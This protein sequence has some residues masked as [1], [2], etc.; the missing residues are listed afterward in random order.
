MPLTFA[1]VIGDPIAH[2]KSPLIH[3]FWLQRLGL[4]GS[5]RATRVAAPQLPDYFKER[6]ANPNWRGCNVTVPH[7]EAV[8]PLIDDLTAMA[9]TVGAVNTVFPREAALVGANTDVEGIV[10]A[11]PPFEASPLSRACLIGSGGAARAA[12]AAFKLQRVA[13]VLLVV[14]N[15]EKGE[16]LLAEFGLHGRIETIEA[17][18]GIDAAQLIVNATTLGMRGHDSM[19]ANLLDHIRSVEDRQ[20]VV[21]DMVYAPLE[22]ELLRV[23]RERGLRVVDGL[24]MLVGQAAIAFELFYGAPAP[25]RDDAALRAL[26]TS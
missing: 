13:E 6:R 14:R 12:L 1:E 3:G 25:R 9:R 10:H 18:A 5:Y 26:L 2:S 24:S 8:L 17:A 22:T 4:D 23:A 15:V 20:T 21:F 19:P 11:L 7:K 16:R